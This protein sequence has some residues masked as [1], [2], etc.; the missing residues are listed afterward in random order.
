MDDAVGAAIGGGD[1]NADVALGNDVG[2]GRVD[3]VRIRIVGVARHDDGAAMRKQHEDGYEPVAT[4]NPGALHL[5]E[6]I[7]FPLS[8]RRALLAPAVNRRALAFS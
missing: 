2:A 4:T 8:A 7:S 1:F 3:E 5:H 6:R